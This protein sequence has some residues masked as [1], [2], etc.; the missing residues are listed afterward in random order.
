MIEML[1]LFNI[2]D[3]TKVALATTPVH[4]ALHRH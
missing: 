2:R 1:F 4:A 3:K